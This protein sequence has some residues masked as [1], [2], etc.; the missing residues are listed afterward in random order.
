MAD[1]V[2]EAIRGDAIDVVDEELGEWIPLNNVGKTSPKPKINQSTNQLS[3]NQSINQSTNQPSTNQS[4]DQSINQSINRSTIWS[5]NQPIN[6]SSI[7]L[8]NQ[9]MDRSINPPFNLNEWN[10]YWNNPSELISSANSPKRSGP[11]R[12][13]LS[14]LKSSPV[15]S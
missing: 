3:T 2:A 14:S 10:S 8:I 13:T 11:W 9:A 4:I 12:T 7:Q 6:Q 5:I 1:F 15:G